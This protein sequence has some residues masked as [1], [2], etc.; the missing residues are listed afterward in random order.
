MMIDVLQHVPF[1][2][3]AAIYDWGEVRGHTFRVHQLYKSAIMPA[4]KDIHFLIVLGGPM[5]SNDP[6]Q[7]L[8]DER[9]LI[10]QLIDD[11]KPV[12]GICLGAQQIAKAL[13]ASVFQGRQKEV[14]W[15]PIQTVS[16]HFSFIPSEMTVFH[17]HGEQFTLP[18]GAIR[19]F[20]NEVCRN[21]GFSYKDHCIGLQFHFETTKESMHK[22]I[23]HDRDYLDDGP[24]VQSEQAMKTAKLPPEN[25]E[26]LFQLL[27]YLLKKEIK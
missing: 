12:F 15:H 18:E 27:D 21:Q 25:K 9:I 23:S 19:L 11:Q 2:D 16:N 3:L 10:R 13:G 1:E 5:S 24:F 6:E 4:A 26:V 14:G 17:W 7:W 22:L 8:E 20:G